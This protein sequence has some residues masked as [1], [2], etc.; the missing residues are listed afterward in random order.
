M[1]AEQ[2]AVALKLDKAS[3]VPL[4]AQIKD[5]LLAEINDGRLA[6]G[7]RLPPVRRLAELSGV[8]TMTIARAYKELA[9]AGAIA[10]RGALGT[11]VLARQPVAMPAP[12]AREARDL[13][14]LRADYA[15][16]DVDTFRRMVQASDGPGMIAFT[17][18]Y[19][20]AS[21][22]D[23][24]SFERHLKAAID[25]RP[26]YAYSYISPA[27]LPS[28]RE[29]MAAT[30]N[31]TRTLRLAPDNI[32]V[33]NG[34]QQALSLVAQLLLSP[35]DTVIVER[36]TYFGALELFR[37]L[38][39]EPV[40][41]NLEPNG[42]DLDMLEMLIRTRAPKLMF[43]MPTFQNP[44]GLTTSLEKRR[45]ILDLARRYGVAIVEDDCVAELR[46]RGKFVPSIKALAADNDAVFYLA[47]MGKAFIPGIRL[48]FVAPP[49]HRVSDVIKMK[50]ISDLHTSPL[51]QDALEHYLAGDEA[52]RNLGLICTRYRELL[53]TIVEEFE[54]HMP[55]GSTLTRPEGGLNMWMTLP[56]GIDSIDFFLSALQRNVSILVGAHLFSEN[57]DQRSVRLS[58]G[59]SDKEATIRGIRALAGVAKD[60]LRPA[61]SRFVAVV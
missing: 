13:P 57:P 43:L 24:A 35:G 15:S 31:A 30:M 59:L 22:I 8:N 36:P 52:A 45:A 27:G 49:A 39:A 12:P 38:G 16:R 3:D 33:T 61:S 7:Q 4:Y 51:Y 5:I 41:V 11:F 42:P 14:A 60:L 20:D 37:N 25:Q 44:T 34:G 23:T 28:L 40:G 55:E 50:S 9:E 2:I 47:G 32:V 1:D 29:A 58:F 26:D 53:A 17:R 56:P 19:P 48:G 6:E 10:G 54:Q 21:V 18:A 46:Y